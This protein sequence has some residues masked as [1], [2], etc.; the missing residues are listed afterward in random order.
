MYTVEDMDGTLGSGPCP[1]DFAATTSFFLAMWKCFVRE[2]SPVF[3]PYVCSCFPP[4]VTGTN[5]NREIYMY[6]SPVYF[7]L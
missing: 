1:K 6:Y 7:S 3:T 5:S 2:L 4:L